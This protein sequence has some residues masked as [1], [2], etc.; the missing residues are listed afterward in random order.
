MNQ[1]SESLLPLQ[2][3]SQ[4]RAFSQGLS[5]RD[6]AAPR[7]EERKHSPRRRTGEIDE[8]VEQLIGG[9]LAPRGRQ[10]GCHVPDPLLGVVKGGPHVNAVPRHPR[11]RHPRLGGNKLKAPSQRQSRRRQY[12]GALANSDAADGARHVERPHRQARVLGL[13]L[14]DV[15]NR[16]VGVASPFVDGS[17]QFV[18][19]RAR[20]RLGGR[21]PLRV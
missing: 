15:G 17:D 14:R 9:A 21:L 10:V 6:G 20:Q 2:V 5:A 18:N 8:F 11:H 19:R 3:D 12:R 13:I 1:L 16:T 7:R 4:V